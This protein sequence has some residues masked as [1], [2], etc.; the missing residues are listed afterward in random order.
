MSD[1]KETGNTNPSKNRRRNNYRRPRIK[2]SFPECPICNKSVKF[3]LTAISVGEENQPAHFDCVLKKI[4]E[5]EEIGPKEKIIYIGNGN[6]AIIK[7]KSGKDLNIR[8]TIIYE[9]KEKT[10]DWR[11]NISKSLKNR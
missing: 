4:S 7:G 3:L 9:Q 5:N 10:A 8:K 11:K 6:F 2:R 1:N